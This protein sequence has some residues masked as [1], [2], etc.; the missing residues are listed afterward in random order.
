MTGPEG[1][2][3]P[4]DDSASAPVVREARPADA[5]A[6]A[7]FA[8]DT[9]GERHD[10]YI[11]RVFPEWAASD[12]PDSGTFVATLPPEA[13]AEGD[14]IAEGD[15]D[16]SGDDREPGDTLVE[17]DGA[18][19]A[20]RGEPEAVVGC[21]QGVL[22]TEWEAWGQ[23]IRVDPAARGFGVGTALSEA[24]LGWARERGA[25]VCRN[26]V[27]ECDHQQN[28]AKQLSQWLHDSE[29]WE[30]SQPWRFER[31]VRNRNRNGKTPWRNL[32]NTTV[33]P[34]LSVSP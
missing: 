17:G 34:T 16:G 13:V 21:I 15:P 24:A 20:A 5:D 25:T 2:S 9:W 33:S 23:G 18:G 3:A 14:A 29:V 6:V 27:F 22:L 12:D 28:S 4:A 7:A 8:R 32:R 1:E 11:P 31:T 10:D 19:A 30:T 26:M